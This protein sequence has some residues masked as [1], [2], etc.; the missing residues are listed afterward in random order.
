M[1]Y[2][3]KDWQKWVLEEAEALPLLEHAYK[4]GINTWDTVHSTVLF[5]IYTRRSPAADLW[6][7]SGCNLLLILLQAD[8]YSNGISEEIIAKALATYH[9]PRESVVLLT[10]CYWGVS[11][12]GEPQLPMYAATINDGQLVN[13]V[14]LSQKHIFD[15]VQASVKRLGT[16]IDVLQI[17]RLDRDVPREEIM[18]AP[19]DVVEK[20]WV[21]YIGASSVCHLQF[22]QGFQFQLSFNR[23]QLGSSRRYKMLLKSMAGISLLACRTTTTLYT[24]KRS[25]RCYLTAE[26]QALVA[27]L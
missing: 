11:A 12:S 5:L 10:K 4:A 14:G 24:A 17:H 15:A 9:I 21:R 2:G 26:T 19:N 16:Y 27:F 18:K 3:S 6:S 1:S 23:W 7:S 22:P 20:G 25:V 13:R 8:L